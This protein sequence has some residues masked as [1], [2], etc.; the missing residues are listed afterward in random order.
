MRT[1]FRNLKIGRKLR[2]AFLLIILFYVI[3][4]SVAVWN[5]RELSGRMEKLYNEP[6]TNVETSL[7]LIANLQAT[8]R[9]ITILTTTQGIV[10]EQAYLRETREII[11]KVENALE[12]LTTGYVSGQEET[13]KLKTMFSELKIP[14]DQ[15]LQLVEEGRG[16]EGLQVYVNEYSVKVDEVRDELAKVVEICMQ[17]AQ[18]SLDSSLEMNG[19]V[20][21][22]I[23]GLGLVLIGFTVALS[24]VIT[25]SIV[26]PVRE[27][28]TAANAIANGDLA[29]HLDYTGSDEMGELA[30]DVRNTQAALSLYVNEIQ[31]GLL[32]L[33]S[34]R[35]DYRSEVEYKG[36]FI[37]V[38][39][40]MEEIGRLLR[41]SMQQIGNSAEQVSAGAEQVA[42]GAEELAQGASEQASSIEELAVSINEIAERVKENAD[43]AVKSSKM[44][45]TVGTTLKE[46]EEHMSDLQKSIGQIK[47]NSREITGII[48]EIEDIAFQTNLLALNASVEAAR[49]G[50]AGRGFSVVAGEV[51]RLAAKTSG[52][53]KLTAELIE[54]NTEAVDAGMHAA[55]V[56]AAALKESVHG[57]EDVNCMVGQ[58]SAVSVQQADAIAQVRKNVEL[59]SDIVQANSATSEESAAASEELSAQAHILRKLVERFDI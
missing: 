53:S 43:N 39:K 12:K 28:K 4:V 31:K 44:A 47:E 1:Y 33:G 17:D 8:A 22:M 58:I 5:I 54:K 10:D 9:N 56:A 48:K 30:E 18:G 37:A 59:I 21:V 13:D 35:L 19:N 46:N 3:T 42:N 38:G 32:A 23:L 14:R 20:M 25:K 52:A 7:E 2:A 50:E 11:G 29:I 49:A 57:A 41:E 26:S 16:E 6:F 51:R 36:D 27:V 24:I 55:E 15:I 34:G 45:D 40:A